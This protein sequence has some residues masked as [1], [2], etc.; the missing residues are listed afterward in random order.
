MKNDP[1]AEAV[2]D[3]AMKYFCVPLASGKP[4]AEMIQRFASP[5]KT[6]R[7]SKRPSVA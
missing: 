6:T 4:M 7:G 3:T 1:F 2:L 5:S